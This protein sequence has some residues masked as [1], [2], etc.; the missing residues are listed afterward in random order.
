MQEENFTILIVDDVAKNIQ[1][2]A[3]ILNN[4]GYKLLFSQSANK[5]IE[6]A[7]SKAIDLILLDIMM[8]EM[9][10][11]NVCEKIKTLPGKQDIPIIFL[12]A[13]NDI[14]SITR[15]FKS[16]GVDYIIKPF[17]NEELLARVETHLKLRNAFKVIQEQNE[18][19]QQLNETKD[20]F[21]SIIAHDLRNPFNAIYMMSEVLKRKGNNLNSEETYQIIDLLYI[22]SKEVYELL[23]NLLTWSRLQ[24]NKLEYVPEKID[25]IKIIENNL[26]LYENIAKSKNI[27]LKHKIDKTIDIF[28]DRNMLNTIIRN[29][30]TNAI[31]FT[32][33]NGYI[34][35]YS[36]DEGEFVKISIEDNGIGMT[37]EEIDQIFSKSKTMT[38]V[39][40]AQERGTGIGLMLCKEFVEMF[41]GRLWVESEKGKGSTFYFTIKKN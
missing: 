19:L 10:G 15:G 22:S 14:E 23:D 36:K 38:K 32:H 3:N 6:I 11:Y 16:G 31:K 30:I 27:E 5:A 26:S 35:I 34:N 29:L 21:F 20:K 37:P 8:P 9:N 28:A 13:K 25:L 1:I 18:K 17:N 4:K 2:V 7:E 33:E 41:Q 24:R 12:T 39:G 40:T